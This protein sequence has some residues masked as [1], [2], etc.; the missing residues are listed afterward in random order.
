MIHF[1]LQTAGAPVPEQTPTQP[2]GDY[3]F[4]H[5][6]WIA[7]LELVI[8]TILLLFLARRRKESGK[9]KFKT[10]SLRQNIDFDNIINSSFHSIKLYDE[11]KVRC[12]PDRFSTDREKNAIAELI[13]QEIT[14]NKTNVK[15]LLELKEEAKQRLNINL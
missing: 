5:W 4:N 11:L 7:I 1:L 14:K 10:E 13:F 15:R 12:H 8:I 3:V 6:M 2:T 9:T